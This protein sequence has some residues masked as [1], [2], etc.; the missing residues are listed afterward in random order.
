M[1][2]RS[3][4]GKFQISIINE[5]LE[6]LDVGDWSRMAVSIRMRYRYRYAISLTFKIQT[7]IKFF[8]LKIF[9]S[10]LQKNFFQKNRKFQLPINKNIIKKPKYFENLIF[11]SY[12]HMKKSIWS[13]LV[14]R[15]NSLHRYR[16]GIKKLLN[17][18]SQSVFAGE[19]VDNILG[20]ISIVSISNDDSLS[21]SSS[22]VCL[23]ISSSKLIC[24]KRLTTVEQHK[25]NGLNLHI[26]NIKNII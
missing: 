11:S 9:L 21:S 19:L 17:C 23:I 8:T 24:A 7:R 18:P 15:E 1:I 13:K 4:P 12:N 14:L 10:T 22:L 5:A 20:L 26:C 2:G 16:F 6:A 3:G 25:R